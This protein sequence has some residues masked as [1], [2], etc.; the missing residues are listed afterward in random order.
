MRLLHAMI[1]VRQSLLIRGE[2]CNVWETAF[3]LLTDPLQDVRA[4]I[5]YSRKYTCMWSLTHG[6]FLCTFGPLPFIS[7]QI[8]F[9]RTI[10]LPSH[11]M[12]KTKTIS[13]QQKT[14]H[15]NQENYEVKTTFHIHLVTKFCLLHDMSQCLLNTWFF[16]ST[17]LWNR[18]Y[19]TELVYAVI[20][21]LLLL[22][23]NFYITITI[24]FLFSAGFLDFSLIYG[25]ACT[26]GNV[27]LVWL[28]NVHASR[29]VIIRISLHLPCFF[30]CPDV[31]Q[32]HLFV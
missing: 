13:L 18:K 8:E 29:R 16:G 1:A 9:L 24:L 7:G 28:S 17:D 23:Y 21:L 22:H 10:N 26:K 3:C 30:K 27:L 32:L 25:I 4:W 31:Y 14:R 2:K 15:R 11:T 5:F 19:I 12:P 20:L 6:F